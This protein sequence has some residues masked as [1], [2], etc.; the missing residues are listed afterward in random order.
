MCFGCVAHVLAVLKIPQAAVQQLVLP[1]FGAGMMVA[2]ALVLHVLA[3]LVVQA[4]VQQLV[5]PDLGA[6]TMAACALVLP[7]LAEVLV[8]LLVL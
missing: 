4:A 6:G 3:I 7:V 8:V 5:L 2:C 1:E